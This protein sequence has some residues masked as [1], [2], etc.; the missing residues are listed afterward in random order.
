MRSNLCSFLSLEQVWMTSNLFFS[1]FLGERLIREMDK[2]QLVLV[3]SIYHLGTMKTFSGPPKKA[4]GRQHR[5]KVPYRTTKTR[6]VAQ[7]QYPKAKKK[8]NQLW[9]IF[10]MTTDRNDTAMYLTSTVCI[11]IGVENQAKCLLETSL[12]RVAA[13]DHKL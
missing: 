13:C 4:G 1:G 8:P 7:S 2:T 6:V 12:T 10:V 3:L 9:L 5:V 11:V